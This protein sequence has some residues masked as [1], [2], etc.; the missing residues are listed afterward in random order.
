MKILNVRKKV[1]QAKR[2]IQDRLSLTELDD[3]SYDHIL[4]E[5]GASRPRA[6][7]SSSFGYKQG[8]SLPH[9]HCSPMSVRT[10]PRG[11]AAARA[12]RGGWLWS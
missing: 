10:K 5:S 2:R 12:E 4:Q 3:C 1:Y 6:Q 8:A 11:M 9:N 7:P